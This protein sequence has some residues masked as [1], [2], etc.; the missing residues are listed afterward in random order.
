ML[1]LLEGFAEADVFGEVA[2]FVIGEAFLTGGEF[3]IGLFALGLGGGEIL[4]GL[5]NF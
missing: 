5:V 1:A 3:A 2:G 4:V